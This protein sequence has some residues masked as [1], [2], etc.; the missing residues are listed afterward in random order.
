MDDQVYNSNVNIK[1]FNVTVADFFKYST[2]NVLVEH[3][4]KV[5]IIKQ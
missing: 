5:G 4:I 3:I 1:D 2:G